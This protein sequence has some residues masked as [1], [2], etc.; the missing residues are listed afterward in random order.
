MKNELAISK[1]L[2]LEYLNNSNVNSIENWLL[3]DKEKKIEYMHYIQHN[4][5]KHQSPNAIYK[6]I[7]KLLR[8]KQPVK[9]KNN[10][11]Q[12]APVICFNNLWETTYCSP[13][14]NLL[15]LRL[16]FKEFYISVIVYREIDYLKRYE[17][18]VKSVTSLTLPF[19]FIMLKELPLKQTNDIKTPT[20]SGGYEFITNNIMTIVINPNY[21]FKM[22]DHATLKEMITNPN[23]ISR[24]SIMDYLED[25][26]T[27]MKIKEDKVVKKLKRKQKC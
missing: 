25:H 23:V 27:T 8:S 3:L 9:I 12:Q 11:I 10:I 15:H 17:I 13:D 21:L 20:V 5:L 2:T 14:D 18:G 7:R 1:K 4:Y 26:F 24:K 16:K 19:H 6:H 22:K